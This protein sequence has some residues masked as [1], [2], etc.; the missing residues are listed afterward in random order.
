MGKIPRREKTGVEKTGVEKTG[1][2][3]PG[4]ERPGW[5]R[6]EWKRPGWKRPE[7]EKTGGMLLFVL[8]YVYTLLKNVI[9]SSLSDMLKTHKLEAF[10]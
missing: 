5:K 7:G 6:P 3:I 10:A 2:K 1:G 9:I 4:G 8:I